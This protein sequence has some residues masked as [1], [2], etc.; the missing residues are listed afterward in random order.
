MSLDER[1]TAEQAFEEL[2]AIEEQ[3]GVPEIYRKIANVKWRDGMYHVHLHDIGTPS[4]VEYIVDCSLTWFRYDHPLN[5]VGED[6]LRRRIKALLTIGYLLG[7]SKD[8]TPVVIPDEHGAN[9][10][11]GELRRYHAMQ[12]DIFFDS[13]IKNLQLT[14]EIVDAYCAQ[15]ALQEAAG[16]FKERLGPKLIY[17]LPRVPTSSVTASETTAK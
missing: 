2:I 16:R 12:Q 13:T 4:A 17:P 1:L 14:P 6:P 7:T 9:Q 10:L 5:R 8:G 11:E 3:D 15:Y